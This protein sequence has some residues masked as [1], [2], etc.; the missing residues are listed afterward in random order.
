[1]PMKGSVGGG[2]WNLDARGPQPPP[3]MVG[4]DTPA[5]VVQKTFDTTAIIFIPNAH[6]SRALPYAMDKG[7]N[8]NTVRHR[9]SGLIGV[10]TSVDTT[11]AFARA[12]SVRS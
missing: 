7:A 2:R 6:R 1:M 10:L 5:L 8:G 4:F 11:P 12:G 9:T 3:C